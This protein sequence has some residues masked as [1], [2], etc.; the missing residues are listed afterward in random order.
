MTNPEM[1]HLISEIPEPAAYLAKAWTRRAATNANA[2]F[3]VDFVSLCSPK[4]MKEWYGVWKDGK[5]REERERNK[6]VPH[7]KQ[8]VYEP[9]R[10]G[11]RTPQVPRITTAI[12]ITVQFPAAKLLI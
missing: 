1:M 7:R 11:H 3:L 8:H 6:I 4:K 9:T 2:A 5:G 10:Y 12:L